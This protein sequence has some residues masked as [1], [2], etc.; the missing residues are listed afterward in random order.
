MNCTIENSDNLVLVSPVK[1]GGTGSC[2]S[3][4]NEAC[5]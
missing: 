4:L 3:T 1:Y 5:A 2:A